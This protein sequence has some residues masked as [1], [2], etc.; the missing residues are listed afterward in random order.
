MNRN[1]FTLIELIATIALLAI[2]AIISFVSISSVLEKSRVNNCITLINNIK[3]A[4][5]EYV[6]D[7]RYNFTSNNNV[8]ISVE[9]LISGR[10]LSNSI[11]DPFS[12]K[13]IEPSK[14]KLI[15]GLNNDYS[16]KSIDVKINNILIDCN[17]EDPFKDALK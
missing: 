4:A 10:Y 9:N 11:V 2:I 16:A 17:G 14:L 15:I 1:G 6:S 5:K 7:N 3:S 8:S 13:E 12:N